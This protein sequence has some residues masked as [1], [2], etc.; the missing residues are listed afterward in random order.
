[1]P[2]LP[3]VETTARMLNERIKG[4]SISDIWTDYDSSFHKGKGNIKDKSYFPKFRK[5]LIGKK[6]LNVE[7]RAKN[8]L[9]NV[10]GGK[11]ILTHMKMTGH[12]LYGKYEYKNKKWF[13]IEDGL[14]K[15]PFNRFVHLV[16]TLSN[17]KHLVLSDMRK[18]AKV[19]VFNTNEIEGNEDLKDLGPEPLEKGFTF[20]KF[21]ERLLKRPNN[22][23][24]TVLMDPEI[25]AGIGNIY[26]D[27]TLWASKIHPETKVK[28]VNN[29]KLESLYRNVINILQQ[30]IKV[31]GDSM[32]DYRNPDGEKGRYQNSH[33]VYRRTGEKCSL[34]GCDGIIKKIKVG[35][36]SAHYCDKHQILN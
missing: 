27:E 36:R 12:F 16:F 13:P 11:T 6:I 33:K 31:G 22:K 23:I 7:R 28:D 17:N 24:K 14:L 20:K 5:E 30:S 26:S 4:L 15:D 34:P 3:E 35:G 19:Y 29:K 8:V 32:S 10:S 1:M 2:E 9:I 21:E 25:I 18:F